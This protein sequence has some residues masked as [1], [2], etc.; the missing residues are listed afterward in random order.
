M[1]VTSRKAREDDYEEERRAKTR[2]GLPPPEEWSE[3]PT[4]EFERVFNAASASESRAD[5]ND[6]F[7]SVEK[8]K[9]LRKYEAAV[10][11]AKKRQVHPRFRRAE[12]NLRKECHSIG[13]VE[14][15][16][17][18]P[19]ETAN[20]TKI[21]RRKIR[22]HMRRKVRQMEIKQLPQEQ[23]AKMSRFHGQEHIGPIQTGS[24]PLMSLN[25]NLPRPC[26]EKYKGPSSTESANETKM[27][28]EKIR[29]DIKRKV[30][31]MEIKTLRKY[32]AAVNA[33]KERQVDP[34]FRR[35]E[36]N[37]RK[38][39]HAIGGVEYE[40]PSP[41]ETTN[42]SQTRRRKIRCHIKRKVLLYY[43]YWQM[44]IKQLSQGANMSRF[45]RQEHK[46]PT[47]TGSFRFV[48]LN[49]NLPRPCFVI[50]DRTMS[51]EA[52]QCKR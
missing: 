12:Y 31:Q 13:G 4:D 49:N 44:E 51:H 46:G 30:R 33:A 17:P 29:L 45:H 20:E 42:Q 6:Y 34:R 35:A 19:T 25:N 47:Q 10:N 1:C 15:E 7:A 40:G 32:E 41:T 50:R 52:R 37:L 11:A 16:G 9:K 36:Y 24:S 39:C 38:E 48:S 3:L 14:Y 8:A 18:S 21:R 43:Y 23:G 28:S 5:I 22:R 27:R 26:F 2:L